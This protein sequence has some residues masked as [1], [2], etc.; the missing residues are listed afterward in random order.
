[1]K[2]LTSYRTGNKTIIAG[3]VGLILLVAVVVGWR[4]EMNKTIIELQEKRQTERLYKNPLNVSSIGDPYVLLVGDTYYCYPTSNGESGYRLYTSEDMVTWDNKG[5][6]YQVQ[7]DS[8]AY[9]DFWAPEVV[10]KDGK[11]YMYYTARWTEND[12]LR[13]GVAVSDKPEGPFKEV[14][15]KPLF[16]FGYA[17]IDANI[18]FDDDKI[19]LY[20]S[21][22]CSE[23]IY[24]GHHESHIYVVEL[25][26]DM[27]S[28]T[29][30]PTLLTQPE[31]DW[32]IHSGDYRW[33]E[34][35]FVFKRG[36]LYYLMYSGNYY[37]D[38]W[39]SIGYATSESPLGPF[40]KY[41]NNPIVQTKI[42]WTDISGPG[43]NSVVASKDGKE[44][45]AVY[46]THTSSFIGGGNRQVNIDKIGFREDG[47]MYVN[48]PTNAYQ[49]KPGY[50]DLNIAKEADLSM[51][52]KS[53]S[54]E[55][56]R[57]LVD[58][59]IKIQDHTG[60]HVVSLMSEDTLRLEWKEPV[61]IDGIQIYSD[62]SVSKWQVSFADDQVLSDLIN[63][64]DVGGS[65]Y[66]DFEPVTTTYI[67]ISCSSE[68]G[69][70][71][72][73]SEIVVYKH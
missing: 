58:G 37:A 27:I 4:L 68:T 70:A 52:G 7:A 13:I 15:D 41:E 16:D 62:K 54:Q 63:D 51:V 8:W 9:K 49:T 29:G 12:S 22:D 59:E 38:R 43:H 40:V 65:Y 39:Y 24:Q 28:V 33:N 57:A 73:L 35:A 50:G 3:L 14:L 23:N 18:L 61:S 55:G 1:M 69:E 56:L 47:T 44:L 32:E 20:Y 10:E 60:T 36:D 30:Q 5:L 17:A 53:L 19:Y 66:G 25:N 64:D 45:Y 42:E 67:E 31:Q 6:S 72:D 71:V 11:F 2:K 21:R 48:G 46:H 34:G 26:E